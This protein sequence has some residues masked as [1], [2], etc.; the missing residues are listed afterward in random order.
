MYMVYGIQSPCSWFENHIRP[1]VKLGSTIF[2][3]IQDKR[4]SP[5]STYSISVA[6]SFLYEVLYCTV[7]DYINFMMFR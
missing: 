5:S 2:S 6:N 1:A 4:L 3:S 7:S